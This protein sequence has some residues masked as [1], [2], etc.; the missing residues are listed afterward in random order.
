MFKFAYQTGPITL[1]QW[2]RAKEENFEEIDGL[3]LHAHIFD[4][5]GGVW[6]IHL[7][8]CV[9]LFKNICVKICVDEKICKN[10]CN[11]V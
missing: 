1:W 8:T 3:V 11:I 10:T 7:K 9:L 5:L 6:Y 2:A 4:S